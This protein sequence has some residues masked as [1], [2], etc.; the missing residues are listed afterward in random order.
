MIEIDKHNH[1]TI[2]KLK[3]IKKNGFQ[4]ILLM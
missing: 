4:T 2:E 1:K 3:E